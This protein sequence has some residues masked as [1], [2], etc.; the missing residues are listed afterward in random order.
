MI[1]KR[2]QVGD[3]KCKE[4]LTFLVIIYEAEKLTIKDG[5]RKRL[6]RIYIQ[7]GFHDTHNFLG[8]PFSPSWITSR[9]LCL[10]VFQC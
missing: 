10:N 5:R 7:S 3:S 8:L 6:H 2:G 9:I 1:E 4:V